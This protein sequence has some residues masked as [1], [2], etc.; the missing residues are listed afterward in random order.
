[1]KFICIGKNYL[2]HA[3]EMGGDAPQEPM[4]FFKPENAVPSQPGV[5][6]YPDFSKDVQFE[7]ELA[8]RIDRP[9]RN[10]TEADAASYYSQV[11]LGI[12][13]TARDLQRRQRELGYP[14]EVCKAF[15]DSAPVG[16]WVSLDSLKKDVQDLTIELQVNRKLVQK[17]N[18]SLMI[19]PVSRLISHVS[20]YVTIDPGD[21]I[22]TGTPE[23]VG[24]V[25]PGDVL[26][27]YLEGDLLLTVRVE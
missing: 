22:L 3:R 25:S 17:G 24:P 18:T 8:V 16:S 14:W 5:F 11:S 23:G 27:A 12:D 6:P 10:V 19:F 20:R 13:F 9:A 7:V 15:E 21:I 4:F 26:E 2:A 1:M